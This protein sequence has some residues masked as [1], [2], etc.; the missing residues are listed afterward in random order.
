MAAAES[1]SSNAGAR[2]TSG[3]RIGE[4]VALVQEAFNAHEDWRIEEAMGEHFLDHSTTWGGVSFRERARI[5]R[6]MLED[7]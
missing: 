2:L 4:L 3:E 5:V 7:A 1:Q 6:T